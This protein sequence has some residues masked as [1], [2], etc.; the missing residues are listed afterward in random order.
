MAEQLKPQTL[1]QSRSSLEEPEAVAQVQESLLDWEQDALIVGHLPFV[2]QFLGELVVNHVDADLVRF[3]PGTIVCLEAP[4]PG[5]W[6]I[7]WVMDGSLF[8][9]Q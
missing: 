8:L 4:Y 6:S 2:A 1:R 3:T 9:K 7:S 5:K